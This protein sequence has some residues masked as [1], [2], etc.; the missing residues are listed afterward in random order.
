MHSPARAEPTDSQLSGRYRLGALLGAG[1]MADVYE[2]EDTVLHRP[3][4]VKVF[5]PTPLIGDEELRHQ[6]EIRLLAGLNHP[7][8]V[9]LFDAGTDQSSITPRTYLVMELISG[10]ALSELLRSGPLPSSDVAELGAQVAESLAYVHAHGI[11][12]RD[13]KPANILVDTPDRTRP[14]DVRAKLTDFG[15]ARLLDD[16]RIT[17]LGLTVGTANYLS[18]EQAMAHDVGLPSDIYSLGLVLL[19][20]L[21]GQVAFP[22]RGVE[23]AGARLH[24]APFVPASLG[25]AWTHL[26]TEMTAASPGARPTAIQVAR[27]LGQIAPS[28]DEDSRVTEALG[29]ATTDAFGPLAGIAW[30][31]DPALSGRWRHHHRRAARIGR[32]T[33]VLGASVAVLLAAVVLAALLYSHGSSSQ[34]VTPTTHESVPEQGG[35]DLPRPQPSL[36]PQ[37]TPTTTGHPAGP[38]TTNPTQ[39]APAPAL[40]TKTISATNVVTATPATPTASPTPTKPTKTKGK[41]RGKGNGNGNG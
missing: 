25:P 5:R 28:A 3:V 8:L 14:R 16:T 36:K 41:G 39:S 12:H 15:V 20:C 27:V 13:V 37:V 26:L 31:H 33:I 7:G 2:A 17:E 1:G 29:P 32:H 22:G 34:S 38:A 10:R 4:A 9:T 21:T 24:R 30:D 19:E 6:G 18:P 11:V 35:S 23:A 40:P